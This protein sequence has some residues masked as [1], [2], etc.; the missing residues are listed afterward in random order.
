[1]IARAYEVYH[2]EEEPYRTQVARRRADNLAWCSC[3]G[4][5]NARRHQGHA[6]KSWKWSVPRTRQEVLSDWSFREQLDEERW[7]E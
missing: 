7:V 5:G 2:Y 4:C 3:S 1:M 6:V